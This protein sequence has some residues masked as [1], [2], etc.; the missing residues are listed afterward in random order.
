MAGGF[1]VT[2]FQ[3]M[4]TD[5]KALPCRVC[6]RQHQ[7]RK[8]AVIVVNASCNHPIAHLVTCCSIG[9]VGKYLTGLDDSGAASYCFV[10]HR[11]VLTGDGKGPT[12]E[13]EASFGDDVLLKFQC[14]SQE[15]ADRV[16]GLLD[17]SSERASPKRVGRRP[18]RHESQRKR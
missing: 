17:P 2:T 4:V 11:G 15:C 10:C 7:E 18:Q 5:F 8:S 16:P 1:S 12:V 6:Q 3:R 9:C 13:Y 14:C